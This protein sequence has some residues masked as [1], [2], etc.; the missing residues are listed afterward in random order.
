MTLEHHN[1]DAGGMQV[2]RNKT[3][4]NNIPS[5]PRLQKFASLPVG[6]VEFLA[7]KSKDNVN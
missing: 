5:T 2:N 1:T 6:V 4:Q 7:A 3:K